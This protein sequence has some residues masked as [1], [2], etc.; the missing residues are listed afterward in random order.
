[1]KLKVSLKNSTLLSMIKNLKNLENLWISELD[2]EDKHTIFAEL[3]KMP[4]LK[5]LSL[6][7]YNIPHEEG[8]ISE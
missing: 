8:A 7:Q 6:G 2:S 5:H 4:K 3:K 1:M